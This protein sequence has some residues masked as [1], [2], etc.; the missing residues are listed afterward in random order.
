M[1]GGGPSRAAV[2]PEP[3]LADAKGRSVSY[4]RLSVT[5][6][7][8]LR[9]LYCDRQMRHVLAHGDILRYEEL[10]EIMGLAGRLG[11]GKVQIGRAHV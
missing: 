10:I 5:D 9:C 3:L 8:N 11:I 6:R 4:L 1:P 2:P 7:C